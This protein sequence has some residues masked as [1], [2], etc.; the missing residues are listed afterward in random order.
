MTSDLF[1]LRL[2]PMTTASQNQNRTNQDSVQYPQRLFLMMTASQNRNRM[3][4]HLSHQKLFSAATTAS[5]NRNLNPI[6][7]NLL[8]SS[9]GS[10]SQHQIHPLQTRS[11]GSTSLGRKM[12]A[13]MIVLGQISPFRLCRSLNVNFRCLLMT[14]LNN[15]N[16]IHVLP[17]HHCLE[18]RHLHQHP[19]KP[20]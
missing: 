18:P 20:P 3:M 6:H 14:S 4:S 19:H 10:G 5:Q 1:R 7:L 2:F 8:P 17:N 16:K 12:H 15:C 9:T 11:I 13:C